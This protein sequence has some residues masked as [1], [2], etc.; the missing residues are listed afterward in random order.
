MPLSCSCYGCINFL[1]TFIN[2][3]GVDKEWIIDVLGDLR[4]FAEENEMP[5]LARQLTKTL[6]VAQ[7]ELPTHKP[8]AHL[9]L[10]KDDGATSRTVHRKT[11]T[12]GNA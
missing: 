5:H 1:L 4:G 6:A 10:V 9:T 2:E 11:G 3:V 8:G 12:S 7:S